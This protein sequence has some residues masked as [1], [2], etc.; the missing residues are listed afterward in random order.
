[1]ENGFIDGTD[2]IERKDSS[3]EVNILFILCT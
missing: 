1:M 3:D 2:D